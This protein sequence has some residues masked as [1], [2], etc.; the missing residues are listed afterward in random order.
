MEENTSEHLEEPRHTLDAPTSLDGGA[1]LPSG[2]DGAKAQGT[3]PP[4]LG[5]ITRSRAKAILCQ[6]QEELMGCGFPK[7]CNEDGWSFILLHGSK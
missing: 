1:P 4:Y 6:V 7:E 2:F 3:T 5:R